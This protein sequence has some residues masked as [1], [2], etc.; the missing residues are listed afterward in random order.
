MRIRGSPGRTLPE[1]KGSL[2]C[3]GTQRARRPTAWRWRFPSPRRR[4]LQRSGDRGP[5]R[6]ALRD[7]I[8]CRWRTS[9]AIRLSIASTM[10]SGQRAVTSKPGATSSTRH[11]V[12][13]VDAEFAV[14]ID[15]LH[16]RAGREHE[17]VAMGR[18]DAGR[19]AGSAAGRSSG[20]W[21]SRLPPI[22]TF[23]QLHAGAD[24]QHRQPPLGHDA[25]S[26]DG[27]TSRG[28]G[29]AAGWWG[30]SSSRR[31]VDR[32]RPRRRARR[33]RPGE[34]VGE[35]VVAFQRRK[36]QRDAARLRYGVVVAA[37][38]CRCKRG[39]A[40]G[41]GAKIGIQTNDWLGHSLALLG[42]RQ[43]GQNEESD[44][45]ER[46]R[47]N[48]AA[49]HAGGSQKVERAS[50]S[51]N[52]VGAWRVGRSPRIAPPGVAEHVDQGGGFDVLFARRRGPFW[53][54]SLVTRQRGKCKNGAECIA[55][56]AIA[57]TS[58]ILRQG[59]SC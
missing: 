53:V 36:D 52:P 48:R 22:I 35:V 16:Q 7:G 30:G 58:P 15:A 18:I 44:P 34:R 2:P 41:S 3:A 43:N 10:P 55:A 14:A 17:R 33:R 4:T 6:S 26:V 28:A 20:M 12:H 8:A 23:K 39:S 1:N 32:G 29:R 54:N 59:R 47:A 25:A 49:A 57:S 42:H 27:R 46:T 56:N 40:G 21:N 19:G 5:R 24:A 51:Q 13:A 50:P 45:S 11:V 38:R 9:R 37:R 31:G